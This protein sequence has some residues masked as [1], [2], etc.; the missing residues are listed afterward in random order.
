[1]TKK[2]KEGLPFF[3]PSADK[4]RVSRPEW[5][6]T[7]RAALTGLIV[8]GKSPHGEPYSFDEAIRWARIYAQA[9]HGERP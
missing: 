6:A 1:M 7:M 3:L 9:A 5:D 8:S 2:K 4:H